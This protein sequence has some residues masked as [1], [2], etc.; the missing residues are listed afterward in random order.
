[1]PGLQT[2][3]QSEVIT[4]GANP[5]PRTDQD[6]L[7]DRDDYSSDSHAKN[8]SIHTPSFSHQTAR[9][10]QCKKKL[11][12]LY[13][14][15][16]RSDSLAAHIRKFGWQCEEV[17][18][19]AHNSRDL[20]DCDVWQALL[21]RIEAG[22]FDAIF[23]S[24]PC[25]TFSAARSVM[26]QCGPRQL[27][28][29]EMPELYKGIKHLSQEELDDV[30]VGNILSDRAVEAVHWFAVRSKPWGVE[31]PAR[32]VGKPSMFRLPKFQQLAKIRGASF[33]TFAQCHFGCKF[34]KLT[35]I[36]GSLDLSSWPEKCDHPAKDWVIPW[37]GEKHHGPH[38]PLRGRQMAIPFDQ[39]NPTM[40]RSREPAGPFLTKSTAHYPEALNEAIAKAFSS[41]S[42]S[43]FKRTGT[44]LSRAGNQDDHLGLPIPRHKVSRT[45]SADD[46][47]AYV[48]GLR[49]PFKSLERVPGLIN[50]GVQIRNCI[51]RFCDCHPGFRDR[52]LSSVGIAG[53][54]P[55]P[56]GHEMLNALRVEVGKLLL[57]NHPNPTEI[58]L[59]RINDCPK[60]TCLKANFMQLWAECANDPGARIVPWLR[61]GAPGGIKIQ[62]DLT[63]LF[64]RNTDDDVCI[65]HDDLHTDYDLFKN[66]EGV[67]DNGDAHEAIQ[68]YVRK[69]YLT[70]HDTLEDCML[71]LDGRLP[72]LS[73]LGCIVKVKTNEHGDEVKKTRI[74]L[75]AKQSLVTS[76]TQRM[77][78][79]ELPRLVDAVFDILDLMTTLE[80]GESVVQMIADIVDAFWLIPLHAS[81]QRFFTA[82]LGGRYLIFRRTAQGSRTAPLTFAAIM[83]LA[84]RFQQSLLLNNHLQ[85]VVWQDGR[86]ET[87]V[88][89]PWLAVKGKQSEIQEV[90]STV[91]IN[92]ELM[93][94]PIAYHKALSGTS[95][96]W[97]GMRISITQTGVEVSIPEEK[98]QEIRMLLE[99]FL[100]TNV[101]PDKELRSFIGKCMN[102]AGVLHVWK[103]FV[104][105]FYAALHSEKP[106]S[107]PKN[108]TWTS[109][110]RSGL[111][112]IRAFLDHNSLN[113]ITKRVWD[114]AE[115]IGN[116]SRLVITWDS[117][118]WGFGATLHQ[119]GVMLEYLADVPCEF[120]IKLLN[121]EIGS[122]KSQQTMECLGGLVA[123]RQW[124]SIWRDRKSC[125]C[126]RSD[127]VGALVLLGR[128]S[129]HSSV[130]NTIAK[131]AALDIGCSSFGPRIS[132]HIPGISNQTCDHLSRMWQ[133]GHDS[134]PPISVANIPRAKLVERDQSW[135]KSV[136]HC[137]SPASQIG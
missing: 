117:S 115:H 95:L 60:D 56:G 89:D 100:K 39:W 10:G 17:D 111:L 128:L 121:I 13:S 126:I 16:E 1:M 119:D 36:L 124:S 105:Q 30:K 69:G 137:T 83:A 78:K 71:H 37:S 82:M 133:P 135:W 6:S 86:M 131:E 94:F 2:V 63:D 43:G 106:E 96:V 108:C 53:S 104:V 59:D 42:I 8:S 7:Q 99:G 31:Q 19:E 76:A 113:T 81:E 122:A 57:R 107:S 134:S 34:Q 64:P 49:R 38:P 4:A 51:N 32:R 98:I 116:G 41:I 87:Y 67:E 35:E 52:Y 11:L 101:I 123:L 27:R 20:L 25:G 26:F 15:P 77:F 132:E 74:I 46:T 22:E 40:L 48:G 112:W 55:F 58:D 92:W 61:E 136:S 3:S 80:P 88:D 130:N 66:Y 50:L 54:S 114:I 91:L 65:S 70:S 84:T 102:I 97:I 120:E 93:G 129:T 45:F 79:S 103:P 21:D 23:A 127:N 72:V 90:I 5:E 44:E 33:K 125:L 62:P 14:G 68:G 24:P 28:G 85:S 118:P 12:Y 9:D 73:K 110:I 47:N 29:A 75:D 109:Q 18:I